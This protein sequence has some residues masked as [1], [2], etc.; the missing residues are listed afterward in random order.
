MNK[1]LNDDNVYGNV[2]YD[3]AQR[4]AADKFRL[5]QEKVISVRMIDS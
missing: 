3:S 5:P 2:L 4:S 1:V